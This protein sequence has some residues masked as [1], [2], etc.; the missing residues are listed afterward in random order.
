MAHLTVPSV[1]AHQV[2]VA[3]GLV[4]FAIVVL[5]SWTQGR[6]VAAGAPALTITPAP[7]SNPYKTGET[8]SISVG[9]NSLFAP[10][11]RIEILEC[12]APKGVLPV[13]DTTCD[14]NTTQGN[15]VLVNSDGSFS[16]TAYTVYALP[17]RAIGDPPD[18]HPVCSATD[19]CVL[20]IGE[21][22]NDFTKPKIFSPTFTF[23]A[24]STTVAPTT[25][26]GK[27]PA[28]SGGS[29]SASVSTSG[30]S[31]APSS[32]SAPSSAVQLSP[33][34]TSASALPSGTLAFTGAPEALPWLVGSG[35]LFMA[36]GILARRRLTR[37]VVR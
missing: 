36:S 5:T 35:G 3:M 13:D 12:A 26:A 11:A 7:G 29:A 1:R 25:A 16:D 23:A 28:A 4:L 37:K 17:D 22:Q 33:V 30:S 6:A 31:G 8:L 24:G 27:A 32:S 20:F 18:S 14:G 10:S 34:S 2:L 9:S 21:D 19:E 15:S